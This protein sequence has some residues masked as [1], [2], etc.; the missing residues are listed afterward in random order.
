MY[1]LYL[2]KKDLTYG[3]KA[4]STVKCEKNNWLWL[5]NSYNYNTILQLT[6]GY[7]YVIVESA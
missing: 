5:D 4:D 2:F 7:V 1:P 6:Y 3:I